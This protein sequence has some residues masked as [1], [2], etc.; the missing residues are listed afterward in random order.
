MPKVKTHRGLSKRVKITARGKVKHS[1]PFRSHLM[2]SKNAKQRRQ[3]RKRVL[4]TGAKVST[5][6]RLL[7]H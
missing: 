2:S 6:K 4:L 3:L 1:R 7:G 5:I